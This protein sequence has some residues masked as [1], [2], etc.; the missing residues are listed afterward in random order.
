MAERTSSL[1]AGIVRPT[2]LEGRGLPGEFFDQFPKSFLD[3]LVKE[4]MRQPL[5]R[6]LDAAL[7]AND[8]VL[9]LIEAEAYFSDPYKGSD[10]YKKGGSTVVIA[11]GLG[12]KGK[13]Y[14]PAENYLRNAG[15]KVELFL[16]DELNLVPLEQQEPR[17]VRFVQEKA[18]KAGS[19]VNLWLHS[20]SG[21]LGYGSY[22][23]HTREVVEN[24][25]R[26]IA[27]G[28]CLPKWVNPLVLGGHFG[29][30]LAFGGNDITWSQELRK[31]ATSTE[32]I[33]LK[34]TTI[35]RDTDP[36]IR[37]G[38][39]FGREYKPISGSH[40]GNGW[41]LETLRLTV[42]TLRSESYPLPAE[43]ATSSVDQVKI[44]A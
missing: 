20:K 12:A 34:V 19:K 31:R 22:L 14:W 33:G 16:E 23:A 10:V 18:Q 13:W 2:T 4:S 26:V 3:F 35:A 30:Q 44:A 32:M 27:V 36:I 41:S 42:E 40:I 7:V 29:S 15:H 38:E 24:V 43:V 11:P 28:T 9:A 25:D 37:K 39:Y 8:A 6:L 17:F 21:I 5:S 1:P